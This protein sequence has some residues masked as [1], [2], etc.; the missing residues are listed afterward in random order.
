MTAPKKAVGAHAQKKAQS[1]ALKATPEGRAVKV[2]T[3]LPVAAKKIQGGKHRATGQGKRDAQQ[4][5]NSSK[6]LV[7]FGASKTRS[8]FKSS[9]DNPMAPKQKPKKS[10]VTYRHMI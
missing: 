3:K 6:G 4:V 8:G 10:V 9:F 1:V 2:A 7:A 5:A